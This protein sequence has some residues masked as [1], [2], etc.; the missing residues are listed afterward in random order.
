V[1]VVAAWMLGPVA[2]AGMEIGIPGCALSA[3]I[4]LHHLLIALGIR[5][6]SPDDSNVAREEHEDVCETGSPFHPQTDSSAACHPRS[7]RFVLPDPHRPIDS[8]GVSAPGKHLR[9]MIA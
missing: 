3:L 4:G 1:T 9:K 7:G 2:C 5:G 8:V 6:D